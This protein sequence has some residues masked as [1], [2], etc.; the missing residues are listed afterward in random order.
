MN[1]DQLYS[2]E[3]LKR[4]CVSAALIGAALPATSFAQDVI[5]TNPTARTRSFN[6]LNGLEI[7]DSCP[8]PEAEECV[9][10]PDYYYENNMTSPIVPASVYPSEIDV[11]SE[12][13]VSG[14]KVT[15]VN[16]R[17]Q[18]ISHDSL[19]DVD[20]LLVGPGGQYSVLASNVGSGIL[21]VEGLSWKFDDSARLPLPNSSSNT[22]RASNNQ[23][24]PL[25]NLVYNEW[26]NVWT[27][28]ETRS[29]KP[30]DYDN[31]DDPEIYPE[32]APQGISTPPNTVTH[33]P[34]PY[35]AA[36][37][38]NGGSKLSAFNGTSPIGTW[39]LYVVDDLFW[40]EGSL[41]GWT[42]EITAAP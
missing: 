30:S 5:G 35:T 41:D 38:V 1:M 14:A 22:G 13:F 26:V 16:V 21:P 9:D 20:I 27:T 15:D 32:P 11:P 34:A 25:Y 28:G 40:Y 18:G 37:T 2:L 3:G 6:N 19:D 31:P 4:A 24:S 8:E 29:F 39:K 33:P 23:N 7:V 10:L 42:I 12:A 17:V 36:P